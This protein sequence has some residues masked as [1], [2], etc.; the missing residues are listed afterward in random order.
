MLQKENSAWKSL[1]LSSLVGKTTLGSKI[2]A[3]VGETGIKKL[4]EK[5]SQN[6]KVMKDATLS[7]ILLY[8]IHWTKLPES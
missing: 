2:E 4:E 5:K 3:Q 7:P 8:R 1:G 6:K